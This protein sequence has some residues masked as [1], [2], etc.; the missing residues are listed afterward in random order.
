MHRS[1]LQ[2]Q[3]RLVK[4]DISVEDV[5]SAY[6]KAAGAYLAYADGDPQHLFSFEGHHAYADR[7]VWS[8]LETKLRHLRD[9]GRNSITIVDAGCGPGTWLRRLVTRAH[10]LGFSTI[11]ARGFDVAEV[12]VRTARCNSRD[13]NELPGVNLT[14][15]VADLEDRLP[16]SDASVDI[17]LCLYSVLSHLPVTS[18]PGITAEIARVT[19]GHLITTVRS[20][21][22]TP[23]V[24]TDSIDKARHVE[25]DHSLNRCEI[26]FC[27]GRRMA[28]RFHLFTAS[29]LQRCFAD[30]FVVEDLRGL[31]IFHGRF[32]PDQRWN[33]ASLVGRCRQRV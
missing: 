22:S 24:F 11:T 10:L 17:T 6:N 18:L 14:F 1:H 12:Q 8:A 9:A 20:I 32:S 16:E 29:E 7:I 21:G 30:R 2:R 25:L 27:D 23:T 3:V 19:K 28:L 26:E 5:A 13:L 15:D 4:S 33:P 31:D